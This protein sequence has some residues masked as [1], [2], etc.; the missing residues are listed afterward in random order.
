M[1]ESIKGADL[2][3]INPICSFVSL[4]AIYMQKSKSDNN[5]F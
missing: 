4:M 5:L 2:L 3:Q 1:A